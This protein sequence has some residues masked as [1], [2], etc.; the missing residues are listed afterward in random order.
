MRLSGSDG[1]MVHPREGE[2]VSAQGNE[3]EPMSTK[4]VEATEL[5]DEED[6]LIGQRLRNRT[7]FTMQADPLRRRLCDLPRF[8]TVRGGGYFFVPSKSALA[9]LA[10]P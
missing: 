6:P 2:A 4:E 7:T 10:Q 8:V 9:F 1:S 3:G 5:Y